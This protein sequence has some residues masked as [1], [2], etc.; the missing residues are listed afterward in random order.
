MDDVAE[1]E[2]LAAELYGPSAKLP[3][4][5]VLHVVSAFEHADGRLHVINI[6]PKSP[7]SSSDFFVL[8]FWRAHADAVLTT[9][10]VV[11][12]EPRLSHELQ[13]EHAA[14]LS[15]YR[16]QRLSKRQPPLCAI[17][18]ASGELPSHHRIWQDRLRNHVLTAP[19]RAPALQTELGSRARVVGID[20]LDPSRAIEWLY[21]QGATC[22][23][24]EAGPSTAG[25]LYRS[26]RGVDHLMLSRCGAQVA[27]EAIGGALPNST[28][29][30]SGL[31]RRCET[32]RREE[33]G[34]WWFSRWD[35]TAG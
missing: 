5:G 15:T 9:A 13:G 7:K 2:R 26:A 8:N 27:P 4:Q 30:F 6:G 14:A 22:V 28:Q 11:R 35:R 24:I 3:V 10:A 1:I 17:L 12:A 25:Q 16:E 20:D 21:A 31:I 18:S 34:P 23:L 29:L 19:A 33:S 32:E